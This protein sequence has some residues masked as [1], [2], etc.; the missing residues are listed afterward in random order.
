MVPTFQESK[1]EILH[2]RAQ[3]LRKTRLFFEERAV[4]EVDT[5]ILSVFAPVDAHIDVMQVDM[6]SGTIGYLHTSPEYGLKKLL[7]MGIGDIYQ[8]SH[9]FRASEEGPMHRP[10]F[11]MLEWYRM[12]LSYEEFIE[13]TLDL[14]KLFL[15]NLPTTILTYSNALKKFA[16]IDIAKASTKDLYACALENSLSIDAKDAKTWDHD[17][18]LNLLFSFLVEPHLGKEELTVITEYPASQAALAKTKTVENRRVALRFEVYHLGL[19]LANG[20]DELTDAKE[21]RRRFHAENEE[22]L[23]MGKMALPIDE[24][25]LAALEKGIPECRGVAVGFDR[26]MLL[27]HEKKNLIHVMPILEQ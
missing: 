20:Y 1:L 11:T 2:D 13:E 4:L 27:R 8:L 15:G 26:L 18:L 5:D 16:K 25:F 24:E 21:Q 7:S 3:M 23:E 10:E 19:E 17:T 9:V 14:I 22:R 6:G 12:H